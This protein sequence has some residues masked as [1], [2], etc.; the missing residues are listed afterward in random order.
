MEPNV[1]DTNPDQ[2]AKS[3][4]EPLRRLE[5]ETSEVRRLA[6]TVRLVASVS[7]NS[8]LVKAALS[9]L[10]H[11]VFELVGLATGLHAAR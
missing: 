5:K 4:L 10:R 6:K 9:E 7:A 3:G 2:L 1:T 11:S 8:A